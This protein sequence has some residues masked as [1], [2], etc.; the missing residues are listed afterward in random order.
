MVTGRHWCVRVRLVVA[1]CGGLS[2]VALDAGAQLSGDDARKQAKS[3]RPDRPPSLIQAQVAF[4]SIDEDRFLSFRFVVNIARDN[5]GLGLQA[6]LRLRIK[7]R[8]PQDE[9]ILGILRKEDWDDPPYLTG[10]RISVTPFGDPEKPINRRGLTLGTSYIVDWR[11]PLK[12]KTGALGLPVFDRGGAPELEDAKPLLIHG[13]DMGVALALSDRFVVTPYTDFNKMT[14]V[15]E[16]WGWHTGVLWYLEVP[17]GDNKD[18][19]EIS[20]RTEY[21]R[22]SGDY[23]GPYFNTV[24][25]IERFARLEANGGNGDTKLQDLCGNVACKNGAA[26]ARNG[27]LFELQARL[28]DIVSIGSEYIAYDG[29]REDGSFRLSVELPAF[30]AGVLLPHQHGGVVRCVCGRR[31]NRDRHRAACAVPRVVL[32]KRRVVA[33]LADGGRRRIW[34]RRRLVDRRGPEDQAGRRDDRGRDRGRWR[35]YAVASLLEQVHTD[36]TESHRHRELI[37]DALG[38]SSHVHRVDHTVSQ[39]LQEVGFES[40]RCGV[41]HAVE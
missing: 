35:R 11:A 12:L 6:P 16:G 23:V 38:R 37:A 10:A 8:D 4:R 2:F 33:S 13:I 41:H 9:E 39:Q 1:I 30:A 28:P 7:D 15:D 31:P 34:C 32:G 24:Y 29:E 18:P 40:L 19:V 3:S 36:G 14:T 5:W 17:R 27:V 26:P 22:V 25:E 20:M 21:R